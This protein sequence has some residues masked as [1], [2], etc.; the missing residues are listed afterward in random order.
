MLFLAMI[1]ACVVVASPAF[2]Q[3]AAPPEASIRRERMLVACA[4]GYP[5]TTAQA[6][7]TMDRF[8]A[9]AETAAGWKPGGLGAVYHETLEGGVARLAEA[10]AVLALVTLP[11]YLEERTRLSLTPR[12]QVAQ[13]SGAM[14]VW[15]LVAKKG[16]VA[17]PTGLDGWELTG[18][19]GFSPDFV[20]GPV[21]GGWGDLPGSVR[22]TFAAA[23]LSALRRAAS[24]EKTAVILDSTATAALPG[25]PFAPDLEIVA[26]SKPL[27]GSLLCS[28]G[29]RLPARDADRMIKALARLHQTPA[30][31]EALKSIQVARFEAIDRAALEGAVKAFGGHPGAAR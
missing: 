24:G 20:R 4:P 31:A 29:D 30:G 18:G 16:L 13:D 26:R 25:L 7:A 8:A 2:A 6:Q 27:P 23:P 3:T 10:D 1:F 14:E 9:A 22:I 11:V 19:V 21:L 15:S 17:L 5:G 12:L 28:V